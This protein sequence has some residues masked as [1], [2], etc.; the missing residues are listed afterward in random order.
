MGKSYY[1]LLLGTYVLALL[2]CCAARILLVYSFTDYETGFLTRDTGIAT[3][4]NVVFL[5]AVLILFLANRLRKTDN[6][7]PVH[8]RSAPAGALAILAGL[9]ILSFVFLDQPYPLMEQGYDTA[10]ILARDIASMVL[11]VLAAASF[12][13]FGIGGLT[14]KMPGIAAV[15]ALFAGIWQVFMLVTRFNSYT[16]LTTIM[17]NLLAV[18][19]MV[20]NTLFL[21]GHAR[22]VFGF[23]SKNGRNYTIPAG[24]CASLAG[25]A[26]VL[27]NYA[28]MLLNRWADIPAILL[29]RWESVYV[30]LM[31]V[32]AAVFVLGMIRSIKLV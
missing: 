28:T 8:H 31:S 18:L 24:L 6:E 10:L 22:T 26:L 21:V 19:F 17:D 9:S 3:A 7:Y 25:A 4:F 5:L 11:G 1:R 32:Y 15:P 16:T 23:S 14:G 2:I 20:F 30:L 29:G 13:L 12:V 27:P